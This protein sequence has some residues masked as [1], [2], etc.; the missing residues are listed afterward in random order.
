[1]KG[2]WFKLSGQWCQIVHPAPMWPVKGYYQCPVCLRAYPV[3]WEQRDVPVMFPISGPRTETPASH[4][5]M[6]H[7]SSAS[8]SA[9][10]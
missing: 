9:A 1:M 8:V 3:P 7:A 5:A 2:L 10:A 6:H 4:S